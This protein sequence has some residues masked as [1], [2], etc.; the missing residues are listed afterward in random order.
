MGEVN[1]KRLVSVKLPL[2]ETEVQATVPKLIFIVNVFPVANWL[3][4]DYPSTS[5]PELAF[6][7]HIP[8]ESV[9]GTTQSVHCVEAMPEH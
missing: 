5:K 3:I 7:M 4:Y 1:L 2:K 9:K 6:K 8:A